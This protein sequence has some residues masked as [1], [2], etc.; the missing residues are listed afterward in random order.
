MSPK[1]KEKNVT[2]FYAKNEDREDVY[3]DNREYH[4]GKT[5]HKGFGLGDLGRLF[6]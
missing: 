3:A 5:S 4:A 1:R 2:L 6:T